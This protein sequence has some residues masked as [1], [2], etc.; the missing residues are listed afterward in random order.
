V[1]PCRHA[2]SDRYDRPWPSPALGV[3]RTDHVGRSARPRRKG[4]VAM[5]NHWRMQGKRPKAVKMGDC[6][7][8]RGDNTLKWLDERGNEVA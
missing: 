7:H 8:Y 5:V 6:P 2:I 4:E 3:A 1:F